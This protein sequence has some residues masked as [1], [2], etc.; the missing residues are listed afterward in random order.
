[1]YSVI[2]TINCKVIGNVF[3]Y[4]DFIIFI[5]KFYK[6]NYNDSDSDPKL[7]IIN[8]INEINENGNYLLCNEDNCEIKLY[9]VYS[10]VSLEYWLMHSKQHINIVDSWKLYENIF[11]N[12]SGSESEYDSKSE[13][14]LNNSKHHIKLINNYNENIL[15][16][17]SDSID[18]S[19]I[20][21]TE[22][23]DSLEFDKPFMEFIEKKLD[24]YYSNIFKQ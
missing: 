24:E 2:D 18:S 6:D 20:N 7:N 16:S 5:K 22:S 14:D 9:N 4:N 15:L 13:S 1:M 11:H 21:N 3:N 19:D 23:P 10:K 17:S 8:N 12:I